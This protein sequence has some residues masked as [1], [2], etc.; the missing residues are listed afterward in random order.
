MPDDDDPT[1]ELGESQSVLASDVGVA[2]GA[3]TAEEAAMRVRDEDEVGGLTDE[4][5]SV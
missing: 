5:S 4:G 1:D 3:A 2:G